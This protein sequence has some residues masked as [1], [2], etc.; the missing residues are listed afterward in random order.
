MALPDYTTQDPATYKANI[1]SSVDNSVEKTGDTMTGDLTLGGQASPNLTLQP[2]IDGFPTYQINDVAGNTRFLIRH[3]TVTELN[4]IFTRSATGTNL[5]ILEFTDDGNVNVNGS[6]PVNDGDLTRKDYVDGKIASLNTKIIDIGDWNMD[7]TSTA[8]PS[9]GL[10]YS[11]I[12]GA[13]VLIRNDTDSNRSPLAWDN[14]TSIGGHFEVRSTDILLSRTAGGV[15]DST[16]FDAT[17][18]N[19]GWII[20][21]YTD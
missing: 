8:A 2:S 17:S 20:I 11:K 13:D 1:D 21:Q 16:D 7:S 4:Q 18:Y 14:G 15:Y 9:H 3:G 6:A 12:V 10:T 19:R 5:T